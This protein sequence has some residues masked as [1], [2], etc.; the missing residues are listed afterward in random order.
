MFFGG[1]LLTVRQAFTMLEHLKEGD[2]VGNTRLRVKR[3][4]Q[5][6]VRVPQFKWHMPLFYQFDGS[7]G[8]AS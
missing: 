8:K 4:I 5:P 3:K 6:F 1:T 7:H 2:Y